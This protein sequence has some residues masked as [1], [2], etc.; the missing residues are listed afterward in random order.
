MTAKELTVVGMGMIGASV[1]LALRTEFDRISILEPND[2]HARHALATGQA[3][4]RVDSV[5]V[6]ADAVLLAC[7]SD[8]I[9]GWVAQLAGHRGLVLDTGSVKGAIIREVRDVLG[10][11]PGNWIPS[12]PIAGLERTGPA[13]ADADLFRGRKVILTPG[14]EVAAPDLERAADWWRVAGAIIEQMDPDEH[15]R[16]YARTSHL[17][18]LL[19]FAYLLGIE[20]ADLAHTGGGFRDFSRIGGSDPV[21]WSGIF[22]RNAPALLTALDDFEGH[23]AEFRQALETGDMDRCR[24]LIAAARA[25]RLGE[26]G[27]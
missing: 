13:V 10:H 2:A 4:E 26:E 14:P 18:H 16:V 1:A 21:M 11:L 6:H 8:R 3:D 23:L 5:P 22:E 25:R 17:P 19:A 20:Q 7:P 24:M 9:A 27:V 12:H 15:D